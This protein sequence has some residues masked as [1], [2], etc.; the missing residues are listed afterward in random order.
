MQP[1]TDA[2][3]VT[4][5]A[6]RALR[7]LAI[8][9]HSRRELARKLVT[10]GYQAADIDVALEQLVAEGAI[11]ESRLAEYYVA[12]RVGKGFGPRRIRGELREK[13]LADALIEQH[14]EP[15]RNDWPDHLAAAHAR[16]FGHEPPADRAEFGRRARFLEQ[17]GFSTDL[18]RR[19]LRWTD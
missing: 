9:E 10:R 18:I 11:N 16:R 12:E 19:L 14:L 17:R 8:R 6:Q 5:I 2:D 7:L 15:L 3:L 4:E 13:G 1:L